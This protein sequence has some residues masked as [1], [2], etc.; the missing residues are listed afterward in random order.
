MVLTLRS[1]LPEHQ[2][3]PQH[4]DRKLHAPSYRLQAPRGSVHRQDQ[5]VPLPS[6]PRGSHLFQWD[7]QRTPAAISS[8]RDEGQSRAG[9][10]LVA[11]Y[12]CGAASLSGA[13]ASQSFLP[14]VLSPLLFPSSLSQCA[15]VF[16][17]VCVCVS[18]RED[19]CV[20]VC[21]G[22]R[23]MPPERS[24]CEGGTEEGWP[25]RGWRDDSD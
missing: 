4:R 25:V 14:P 12:K 19:V 22:Q 13:A 17:C 6:Q 3:E 5:T 24:R 1:S 20:C 2:A 11:W 8:S 10:R 9:R 21:P 16:V 15:R 23:W 18:A 7:L